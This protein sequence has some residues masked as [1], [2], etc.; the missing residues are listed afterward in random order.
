M[1][2]VNFCGIM[3]GMLY[4]FVGVASRTNEELNQRSRLASA[5][6]LYR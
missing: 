1:L 4:R 2:S 3:T 5:L 6:T